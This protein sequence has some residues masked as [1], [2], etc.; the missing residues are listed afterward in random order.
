MIRLGIL[1]SLAVGVVVAAGSGWYVSLY[2]TS[3]DVQRLGQVCLLVF[4]AFLWVKVANMI[5][6]GSVLNAGGDSRFVLAMESTATW[7]VG[8][9]TAFVAAFVAGLTVQ[10]VYLALSLEEVVRLGAG[11]LRLRSRRWVRSLVR[12]SDATPPPSDGP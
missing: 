1:T 5:M 12:P 10:W 4:C 7:M 6:A 2:N 3:P 9:P 8:V 11:Y